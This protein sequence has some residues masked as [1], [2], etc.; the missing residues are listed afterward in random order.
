MSVRIHRKL[1]IEELEPRVS[2]VVLVG[3]SPAV[4]YTD[5]DGD[6]VSI[7]FRGAGS[8]TVTW[9]LG[10]ANPLPGGDEVATVA[11]AGTGAGSS[12]DAHIVTKASAAP[13]LVGGAMTAAPGVSMGKIT[14]TSPSGIVQNTDINIGGNLGQLTITGVLDNSAM[15]GAGLTVGGTS[16]NIL[17][18]GGMN[19]AA[20][21]LNGN[22]T[23]V[24]V[25][26]NVT[27]LSAITPI[28][29]NGNVNYLKVSGVTSNLGAVAPATLVGIGGNAAKVELLN[30]ILC[31]VGA[32]VDVDIDGNCGVF[33]VRRYVWGADVELGSG[34]ANVMGTITFYREFD[35]STLTVNGTIRTLLF[36]DDMAGIGLTDSVLTLNGAIN[37][38]GLFSRCQDTTITVNGD[39][40]NLKRGAT[41]YATCVQPDLPSSSVDSETHKSGYFK[42]TVNGNIRGTAAPPH[43]LYTGSDFSVTG[44]VGILQLVGIIGSTVNIG[45]NVG[46][47]SITHGAQN[48]S[49]TVGGVV[50]ARIVAYNLVD[51]A[52]FSV[53][54][55]GPGGAVLPSFTV[56]DN[57]ISSTLNT[58]GDV[59]T[60]YVS[61]NLE[62]SLLSVGNNSTTKIVV[63]G[64]MTTS[65]IETGGNAVR[66]CVQGSMEGIYTGR[67]A[68]DVMLWGP[69]PPPA[70]GAPVNWTSSFPAD[71]NRPCIFMD[72]FGNQ[73]MV[74]QSRANPY[75]DWNVFYAMNGG[76]AT[77]ISNSTRDDVLPSVFV[78]DTNMVHVVWQWM[79]PED[80]DWE[81]CY[82]SF[83]VG[84]PAQVAN[85]PDCV[86]VTDRIGRDNGLNDMYPMIDQ[87]ST[88]VGIGFV[89]EQVDQ[90]N[91]DAEP[92]VCYSVINPATLPNITQVLS[93]TNN[94][95]YGETPAINKGRIAFIRL[96]ADESD[97]EVWAWWSGIF[98]IQITDDDV[99]ELN[100]SIYYQDLGLAT[101][102]RVYIAFEAYEDTGHSPAPQYA[103]SAQ[104]ITG[105]PEIWYAATDGDGLLVTGGPITNN[106]QGEYNLE[107]S[108]W[109]D[110]GGTVGVAYQH[111]FRDGDSYNY[112]IYYW[113]Q[114]TPGSDDRI[115]TD[116]MN[117]VTP[118]VHASEDLL[119][120]DRV[121]IAYSWYD[122]PPPAAAMTIGNDLTW[123]TCRSLKDTDLVVMGDVDRFRLLEGIEDN[124]TADDLTIWGNVRSLIIGNEKGFTG[125]V[126]KTTAIHIGGNVTERLAVMGEFVAETSN[127]YF[128]AG[129][130]LVPVITI[131]GSAVGSI[132]RIGRNM[133]G[134]IM[135]GTV[136]LPQRFGDVRIGGHFNGYIG[137]PLTTLMGIKNIMS[138]YDAPFGLVRPSNAFATYVGYP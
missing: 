61:G 59:G 98:P 89:W 66:V 48:C 124:D 9:G 81:I 5:L 35:D 117:E 25:L 19:E 28:R 33:T 87:S 95:T 17:I 11:F 16:Q 44:N 55:G 31:E 83:P 128:Y 90:T 4:T 8:A 105:E 97:Y 121:Q 110:A 42:M 133:A 112:D 71:D 45:G 30:G 2:P 49:I 122:G 136:A 108:V 113:I 103:T 39:I 26:G 34:P 14:L 102:S 78:D 115:T 138:C 88:A 13:T 101:L 111:R 20:M 46:R 107:P 6:V 126:I 134:D 91:P 106:A 67:G 23:K 57:M 96:E 10:G 12:Y 129:A 125:D 80:E 127:P 18:N 36:K 53:G 72:R 99:D 27:T 79:D 62:G 118:W 94:V 50:T 86:V 15:I 69:E 119:A 123:M 74:W 130:G 131:D 137:N 116:P 40:G 1:A 104:Q 64:N 114:G 54:L 70:P 47:I 109:I 100:P 82:T 43:L 73:H 77:E 93:S 92:I 22:A 37:Q 3:N 51:G 132:I 41:W 76:A 65:R 58:G 32:A 38:F 24:L 85:N 120:S 56:L 7:L 135:V 63:G 68:Y 21:T 84:A 60:I 52:D 29:C 75:V